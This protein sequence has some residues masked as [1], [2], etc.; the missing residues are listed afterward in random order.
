MCPISEVAGRSLQLTNRISH[1]PSIP[2]PIRII[3][4]L[5]SRKLRY[6]DLSDLGAIAAAVEWYM[7]AE[8]L[9]AIDEL[10]RRHLQCQKTKVA[11]RTIPYRIILY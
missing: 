8:I 1:Q 10:P 3:T 4:S 7:A 6:V 5:Y 11:G 9:V 2:S